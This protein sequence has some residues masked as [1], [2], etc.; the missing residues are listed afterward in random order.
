ME[1]TTLNAVRR[2]SSGTRVA[3][4]LRAT[5]RVPAIMY[6]HGETPD[7]VSLALHDVEVSLAH[8]ART[9]EIELD[10]KRRQYLIKEVQYDHLGSVPLHLDLARVDVDE[11]VKVRVGIEPRGVAKG[12]SEGGVMD[13]H[14]ADLEI[15]CLVSDIPDTL[16]PLVTELGLGESLLVKDLELPAG[17]VALGDPEERVATVRAL[18]EEAPAEEPEGEEEKDKAEPERIG[19]IRKEEGENTP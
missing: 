16:H 8:G 14:M 7:S 19:R 11:R 13:L 9:M 1:V 15:E 17:V 3:K 18:V 10:G 12:L 5:G 4:A 2:E 6:G